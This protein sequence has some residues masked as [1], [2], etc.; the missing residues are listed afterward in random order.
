VRSAETVKVKP[1]HVADG[2]AVERHQHIFEHRPP[3]TPNG[4][5]RDARA[6]VFDLDHAI[7]E[8]LDAYPSRFTAKMLIEDVRENLPDKMREA[9]SVV[10]IA[11]EHRWPHAHCLCCVEHLNLA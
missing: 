11:H 7:G 8:D 3:I 1:T 9:R 2:P 5:K 6:I 4:T 10:R